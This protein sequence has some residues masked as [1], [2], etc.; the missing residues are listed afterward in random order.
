MV[1]LKL[2]HV[3]VKNFFPDRTCAHKRI[4]EWYFVIA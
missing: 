2:Y 4:P 1:D 3:P